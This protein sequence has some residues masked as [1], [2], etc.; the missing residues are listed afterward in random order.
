MENKPDLKSRILFEDNHILV[1]QKLPGEMSQ[2]DK[3]GDTPLP[4]LL[5]LYLKEK[6]NKPGAVFLGVVHRLDRPVGGVMVFART[7][8]ALERLNEAF[9]EGKSRKTYL[10]VTTGKPSPESG[11][12]RNLLTRNEKLNKSFIADAPSA[13]T[14][15]AILNYQW[16]GG[17]DRYSLIEI[18]L[19][20]GRHHQ[21][22]VQLAHMGCIIKGDLKYGAK[23]SNPDGSL[24]L[25]AWKL[26]FPHPVT[27]ELL[28]FTAP[29]PNEQPWIELGKYL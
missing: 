25:L 8:K 4:D 17:S 19:L 15:E 16:K 9:R 28:S 27:K 3:T 22:R 23:R 13:F 24:S 2:G 12:L 10:A 11:E 5:K 29:L 14:K 26:S 18:E 20:T 1:V 21:I 7:S 6:Y